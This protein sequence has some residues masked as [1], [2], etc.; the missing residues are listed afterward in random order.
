VALTLPLI[1]GPAMPKPAAN[2]AFL[3]EMIG[4]PGAENSLTMRSNWRETP[5][6]RKR[7]LKTGRERAAFFSEKSARLHFGPR[8]RSPAKDQLFPLHPASI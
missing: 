5:C 3:A 2:D 8:Q 1:T 7:C 4:P 6:L